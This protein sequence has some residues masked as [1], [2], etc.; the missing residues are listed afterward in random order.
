MDA[1]QL[2]VGLGN[3]GAKYA[4]NRHNVGFMAVDEIWRQYEFLAWRSKFQ[5]SISD[6]RIDDQKVLLLKPETFMNRS[7]DA[8]AQAVK[9]YKLSAA[10][11]IVFHD[12]ID[13]APGKIRVKSGGGHAGHNG[14][15]S[16]QAHIGDGFTRVRIG[17][18]HPGQK[19]SVPGYVLQDFPKSDQAWLPDLLKDI[20]ESAP[21]LV[22]GNHSG[23]MNLIAQKR[24]DRAPKPPRVHS[25]PE[26][27]QRSE[28]EDAPAN[29]LQRLV[30]KFR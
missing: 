26:D 15:R 9:F 19:D 16:L 25:T 2:I 30:R 5:S 11:V 28:G 1:V 4:G 21:H 23:F 6:G 22:S 10:D 7:G 20:A 17:V 29:A 3:P 12:E 24:G 14:L 18:G 13:L 8:V 27:M